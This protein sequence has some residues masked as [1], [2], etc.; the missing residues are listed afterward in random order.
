MFVIFCL[1]AAAGA[2]AMPTSPGAA[3][4][5]TGAAE[6]AR[7]Q[8]FIQQ[9]QRLNLEIMVNRTKTALGKKTSLDDEEFDPNGLGIQL[10]SGKGSS[11]NTNSKG[12]LT[13][14]DGYLDNEPYNGKIKDALNGG[15]DS[16]SGGSNSNSDR[17]T[18]A[19]P[20][21]GAILLGAIGTGLVGWLRRRKMLDR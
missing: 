5:R 7:L 17:G 10:G 4:L 18:P 19:V 6:P 12:V 14:D 20:A 11:S 13:G 21:P 3:D 9:Q 8:T 1:L 2:F 16:S 15:S